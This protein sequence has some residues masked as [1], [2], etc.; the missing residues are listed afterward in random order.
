MAAALAANR[1]LKEGGSG[2]AGRWRKARRRSGD[3]VVARGAPF[4][5]ARSASGFGLRSH[6]Y[7]VESDEKSDRKDER[8]E[9]ECELTHK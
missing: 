9:R 3:A 4:V 7:F 5:G 8:E 2:P 6:G 1:L